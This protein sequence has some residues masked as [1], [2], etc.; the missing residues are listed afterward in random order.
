MP[1]AYPHPLPGLLVYCRRNF[2]RILAGGTTSNHYGSSGSLANRGHYEYYSET[3]TVLT[4]CIYL[5]LLSVSGL[6]Q[7]DRE[8][9]ENDGQN[10]VEV[11]RTPLD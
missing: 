1:S 7:G 10:L 4:T 3:E 5:S 9:P 11:V 2:K 6:Q 8:L